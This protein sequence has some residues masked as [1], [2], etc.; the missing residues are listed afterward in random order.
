MVATFEAAKGVIVLAAGLGLFELMHRDV[1]AGAERLVRHLNL[2]PA[3]HYPRVFIDASVWLDD[4]HLRLLAAGAFVYAAVR[5]VEAFGLWRARRWAEWFGAISGGIYLPLE[6]YKLWEAVTWPRA[7][8]LTV[9]SIIVVYLVQVLLRG[10]SVPPK[11]AATP[12][13]VAAP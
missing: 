6:I 12:P 1:Q 2:N 13:A 7:T 5:F 8:I 4:A 11:A 3:S 10:R 9:N